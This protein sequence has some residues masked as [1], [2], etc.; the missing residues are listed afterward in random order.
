MNF[1]LTVEQELLLESIEEF[2]ERYF[3]ESSIKLMYSEGKIPQ[4][5]LTAYMDAGFGLMGIPEEIGGVP[6]DRV[7][8]GLLTEEFAHHCGCVTPFLANTLAMCDMVDFG[9]PEQVEL[10]M[11]HYLESG[12]PIFSLGFSEPGAGSDNMSM[13]TI[14]KEQEDGTFILKGQK[15]WVT[16]GDTFPYVLVIA[17][18]EDPSRDNPDMTMWLVPKDID[19]LSTAPL[20]K[21]GQQIIPFCEMYF[22]DVVLTS[23]MRVGRRHMGFLNLMKNYEIERTLLVAQCLGLAQ[24]AMDD[25]AAYASQRY[26]FGAPIV[27]NQL[28]M[29]KLVE[30]ELAL[31]NTRNL[32]YEVLSKMDRGED[33]SLDS[34][35]LK[36]YGARACTKVANEAVQIMGG[37]GYT[38]EMRVGRILLDLRGNQIAGGTNEIMVYSAAP[39]IAAKYA[40]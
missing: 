5:V 20:H 1:D 18:E 22:D 31:K 19:G 36:Y 23:D 37:L 38:D 21:I 32:L 26:A 40:R 16:Q 30:M 15:T 33:V 35:L 12:Q 14:T 39:Q 7:T 8:L 10:C 28:I 2:C 24:A 25:A 27:N 29:L 17:K 3:D 34:S 13:T 9:S 11:H 6:S 4:E